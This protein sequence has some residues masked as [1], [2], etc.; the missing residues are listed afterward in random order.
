MNDTK[1]LC[2]GKTPAL[3]QVVQDALPGAAGCCHLELLPTIAAALAVIARGGVGAVVVHV[4]TADEEQQVAGI[5]NE[6]PLGQFHVPLIVVLEQEDLDLR[7]R[8]LEQGAVDCLPRPLDVSRLAF[9]LD[10]LTV[11]HRY[12]PARAPERA[13]RRPKAA[14]PACL[15]SGFLVVSRA[16]K[17]LLEQISAVASLDSTVLLTGETGTGKSHV[18]Q[19]IHDLSLRKAQPLVVVQCGGLSP[20]LLESELFGHVRG[21]FTGADRDHAGKFAAAEDGTILLDEIDCVP[22]AGQAKLLRVLERRVYEAVGSNRLLPFR[23][24]VIAA[25]NRPLSREVEAGRFRADLYYRLCVVEFELPPLRRCR[26][27]IRPL[28]AKFLADFGRREQR[29]LQG[30]TE[31]ALLA[32]ELYPW[33]GNIREL[34]NTIE[35]AVALCP[36][37]R[38]DICDL[39]EEVRRTAVPASRPP[40]RDGG[41]PGLPLA[42]A[43]KQGELRTLVEALERHNN[44]RALVATALGISRTALYKKLH[45]HGLLGGN[46]HS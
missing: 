7:R 44:N 14:A 42:A 46:L 45:E 20:A 3:I 8:L 4:S 27:A 1:I 25:T 6:I 17:K 30:L 24:R 21:A 15:E 19:V 33:P 16:A 12:Q 13:A 11:R 23:G 37:D 22:P 38:I 43:R 39:P 5:L 36:R 32:L 26:E 29:S 40:K 2:F 41:E 18:A 35:R 9:L 28:A 34:R 31:A 10:L